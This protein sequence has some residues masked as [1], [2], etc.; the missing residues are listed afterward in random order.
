MT[1]EEA[2]EAIKKT[3]NDIS[4]ETMK[5]NPAIRALG[6]EEL[7]GELLSAVYKLTIDLEV[8]K[9]MLRKKGGTIQRDL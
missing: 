7:Q 1:P 6:N 8:I 3:C 2:V 4:Q 9:K 5:L